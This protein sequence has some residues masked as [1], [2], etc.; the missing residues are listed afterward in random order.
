M[1]FSFELKNLNGEARR[2]QLG[3]VNGGGV[4]SSFGR[5]DAVDVS[6]KGMPITELQVQSA[7]LFNNPL[8]VVTTTH[9][10]VK[11]TFE[12]A[13]RGAGSGRGHFPQVS[14]EVYL[15]YSPEA[16]EQI[17]LVSNNK[18]IGIKK[19]GERVRNLFINTRD[20]KGKKITIEIIK[21]GKILTP[22]QKITFATTFF[23]SRGGD[24]YFPGAVQEIAVTP[25]ARK[26]K[27]KMK[28]LTE[29]HAVKNWIRRLKKKKRWKE[30]TAYPDP[31]FK[32][33]KSFKRIVVLDPKS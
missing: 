11:E 25:I 4:R 5:P 26:I 19:A 27:G 7:L 1:T 21:D 17:P 9:A 24:G 29:Q 12:A 16:P 14:R 28:H 15:E 20:M 31:D 13:L 3:L 2:G 33:A 10:V 32:D 8:R 18:V 30:G 22:S 23:L 6:K